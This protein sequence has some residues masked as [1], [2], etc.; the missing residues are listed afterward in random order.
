MRPYRDKRDG[1]EVGV[2][3]GVVSAVSGDDDGI[4]E[5][6]D[7]TVGDDGVGWM[8][9]VICIYPYVQPRRSSTKLTFSTGSLC[10]KKY[11]DNE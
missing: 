8:G 11:L 3:R 1:A 10:A 6:D 5:L 9:Q 4:G 2:H 7:E